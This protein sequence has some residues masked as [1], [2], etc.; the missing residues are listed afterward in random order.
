MHPLTTS[1]APIQPLSS[2]DHPIS[3]P[4]R[5]PNPPLRTR[6]LG[7][8]AN[9]SDR[10]YPSHRQ[11]IIL[12]S[13]CNKRPEKARFFTPSPFFR[14][15]SPPC[16]C[17][18]RPSPVLLEQRIYPYT[19]LMYSHTLRG[20]GVD[21]TVGTMSIWPPGQAI[22]HWT[23]GGRML[24]YESVTCDRLAASREQGCVGESDQNEVLEFLI[25]LLADRAGSVKSLSS[26]STARFRLRNP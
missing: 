2:P 19:P 20:K 8:F 1:S 6:Q 24:D 13:L 18:A 10:A 11:P 12:N 25:W 9:A 3:F 21:T 14:N 15:P 26:V 4:R 23:N 16:P 5:L 22:F 17:S 7:L